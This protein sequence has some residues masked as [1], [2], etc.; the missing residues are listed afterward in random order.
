ME[1]LPKLDKKQN[2]AIFSNSAVTVSS[3]P[4]EALYNP[5]LEDMREE[6]LRKGLNPR[7]VMF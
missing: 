3:L 7:P 1:K 5:D 6:D 4:M 2:N